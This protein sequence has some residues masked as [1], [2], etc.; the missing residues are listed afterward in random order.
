MA[1]P[2]LP[3][4]LQRALDDFIRNLQDVYKDGLIS[5]ILY[6]SAASGEFVAKQ[7][8]VNLLVI[9]K[10]A[11]LDS[12]SRIVKITNMPRF[13]A[14]NS[15]FFT[16]EY[17]VHSID[18]F[19]IEFLDMK[20]NYALLY[21]KD[22]LKDIRVDMKNLR[23]QCEHELKAKLINVKRLYLK[24]RSERE[25]KNLMFQSFT[26]AM[27]LLRNLMR[28]KGK[29]PSYAKEALIKEISR[30]FQIEG[31]V[32]DKIYAAKKGTVRLNRKE[33]DALFCDFVK[34]LE[35]AVQIVDK[36]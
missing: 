31:T 33:T 11:S 13:Q 9:L 23:F 21:G 16:E 26:S 3:Q 18:V 6:G 15:F 17:I 5:I 20:E 12:L 34:E 29:T 32:F 27:H 4:K 30:E 24:I 8:N 10:D 2:N 19:P 25:L 14:L 36:L 22:V 28:L 1:Q 35:T 7:S